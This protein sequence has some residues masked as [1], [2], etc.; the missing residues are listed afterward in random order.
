VFFSQ[1]NAVTG[2]VFEAGSMNTIHTSSLTH[3]IESYGSRNELLQFIQNR[4]QEL[5]SNGIWIN[6]DVVGL[7]EKN[8]TVLMKL[9]RMDGRNDDYEKNFAQRSELKEYLKDLSTYGRFLR[10]AE[11]FRKKEGYQFKFKEQSIDDS[12]YIELSAGRM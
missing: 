5:T 3:E 9:N 11:D 4:Y 6:R 7:E 2:L 10:F 12:L 1:R 8:K